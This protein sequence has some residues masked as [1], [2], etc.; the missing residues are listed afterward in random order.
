M[1]TLADIFAILPE[2]LSPALPY[3]AYGA[4]FIALMVT[5]WS[6]AISRRLRRLILRRGES[7]EDTLGELTRRSKE[8]QVFR[9]ELEAYLKTSE[10]RLRT[11]VRGIGVVR[12]NPFHGDGTGGN[13]SFSIVILDERERGVVLST[14]YARTGHTSIYAKPIEGGTSTFELTQEEREALKRA[15]ESLPVTPAGKQ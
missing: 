1:Q 3:A 13:Q 2:Y 15:K 4:L 5:L 14:L 7:L 12:F 8:L 9:E 6:A 10:A 11:S